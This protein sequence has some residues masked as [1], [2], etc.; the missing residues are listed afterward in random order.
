MTHVQRTKP[1]IRRS[2]KL[3]RLLNH[4]TPGAPR[5]LAVRF[6]KKP[7][8]VARYA[9]VKPE[10]RGYSR[11]NHAMLRRFQT[12]KFLTPSGQVRLTIRQALANQG[13][14]QMSRL[15]SHWADIEQRC[16]QVTLPEL[17]RVKFKQDFQAWY[18]AGLPETRENY[19]WRIKYCGLIELGVERYHWY[20]IRQLHQMR[21][22]RGLKNAL[23][24]D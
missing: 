9:R 19:F 20:K 10:P 1:R 24:R 7:R 21:Q 17:E 16:N 12:N 3:R 6:E 15:E 5:R 18:Q 8:L 22:S 2:V 4:I 13:I 23:Y 11:R 14:H